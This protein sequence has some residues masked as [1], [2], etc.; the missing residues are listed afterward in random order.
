MAGG[1]V[2]NFNG[3]DDW[4]G[5]WIPVSIALDLDCE[6]C[7]GQRWFQ[8]FISSLVPTWRPVDK[9]MAIQLNELRKIVS[10]SSAVDSSV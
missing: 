9:R 1:K 5:Y 3:L 6:S 8:A 2:M 4:V 10:R 7:F